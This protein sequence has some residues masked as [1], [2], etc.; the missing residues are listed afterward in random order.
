[1]FVMQAKP[2]LLVE[3]MTSI[4]WQRFLYNL[5]S[6]CQSFCDQSFAD[7]A[8][9]S[10][11]AC[12]AAVVNE[13]QTRI[14]LFVKLFV[15]HVRDKTQR[16]RGIRVG[17]EAR[18]EGR[19]EISMASDCGSQSTV[20]MTET[21]SETGCGVLQMHGVILLLNAAALHLFNRRYGRE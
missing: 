21:T 10:L 7:D 3:G 11:F 9:N 8:A 19:T 1:M 17:R 4:S 18:S 14:P 5:L 6:A 15:V 12:F 2:M 20:K 16:P 13:K